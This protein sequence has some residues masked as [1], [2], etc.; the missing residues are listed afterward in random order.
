MEHLE[1]NRNLLSFL[2]QSP[3]P[4]HAVRQMSQQLDQAGF[5][6]L[7]EREAWQLEADTGYYVVRNGSSMVAFRT[8]RAN[9][10]SAGVRMVGA[11]SDSPCLKVKPNP[12]LRRKGYFQVGVEVYGGVL[13]NPWFDRDLSLA[14]RVT[15]LNDAGEVVDA[16]VD[17]ERPIAF[18]PSLAIHLDRDANNNRSVNAQTDLPPVLMQVGDED[19]TRFDEVVRTQLIKQQPKAGV[20]K[21]LGY[22]LNFYDVQ[23]GALIGLNDEFIASARLDNLLSCYVGVQA[24]IA[25]NGEQPA[26]FVCND[27]EEVGS[28]S[29]EGAQGPFLK[30]VLDRWCGA[31]HKTRVIARSMMVSADNAHGVHPNFIS[32]HDENHGPII[33]Q[34]PVIKVNHNQRYATNSRS[35]SLYRH[36][37]DELGLPHQ[38]FVVRSDMGCGS[39]IGPLTAAMLGITTLDVGVPQFG[40][41]SIRELAGTRDSYTLYQV[42]TAFMQW[43]QVN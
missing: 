41:H 27:H 21:I 19:T 31:D 36:I 29:A 10:V 43:P 32:K 33:N 18:I 11:H 37:S 38:T 25:A 40:M 24:L 9:P 16:L 5:T 42:I 14:G 35:A 3:T 30:S 22:E 8:G 6:E 34:G 13:L 4:W 23:P 26:L 1:F 17:F 15:Y 7:D 12:E 39:T 20:S 2:Q 28:V